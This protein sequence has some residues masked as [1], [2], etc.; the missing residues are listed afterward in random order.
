M[1]VIEGYAYTIVDRKLI[2]I[3]VRVPS[4]P[5]V[6]SVMPLARPPAPHHKKKV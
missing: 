5:A 3:D 1:T 6:V 2:I 4:R